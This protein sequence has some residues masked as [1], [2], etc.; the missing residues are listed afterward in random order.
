MRGIHRACTRLR[1]RL[2][3]LVT[4]NGIQSVSRSRVI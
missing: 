3:L 1:L 4:I 2:R